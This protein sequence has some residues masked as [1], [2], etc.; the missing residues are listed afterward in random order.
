MPYFLFS[1]V[2]R[3]G[4]PFDIHSDE[5]GHILKSRRIQIGETIQIQDLETV[6]FE[7]RVEKLGKR[8]LTLY[9]MRQLQMP[10]ESPFKIHLCQALVKEKALDTIIQKGTELGVSSICVF[11][12]RFSQRLHAKAE[13][14]KKTQ[15][16]QR[17]AIEACKQSGRALPPDISFAFE[18]DK[19]HQVS[20]KSSIETI[21]LLC[22]ESSGNS[23]ALNRA[24]TDLSEVVLIVGP[25]GGWGE[26]EWDRFP[27]QRVHLGPRILRSETAAIA[28][29]TILQYQKGDLSGAP[30]F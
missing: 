27:I 11:Q 15:R 5:A 10:P 4:Q 18:L 17:I 20:G 2:I 12:S 7:A 13:V 14:G 28:G 23:I 6:R 22:L 30:I 8:S 9:P 21:P 29:I 24:N 25:E 1:G 16:W 19:F 3:P 26:D